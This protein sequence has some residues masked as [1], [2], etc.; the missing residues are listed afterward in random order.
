MTK[1][2]NKYNVNKKTFA[3]CFTT[4]KTQ[5]EDGDSTKSQ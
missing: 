3:K 1:K 2:I 5:S 4:Y